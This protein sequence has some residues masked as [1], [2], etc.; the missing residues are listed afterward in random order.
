LNPDA[1]LKHPVSRAAHWGLKAGES[2]MTSAINDAF[3]QNG[4]LGGKIFNRVPWSD[5]TGFVTENTA[6]NLTNPTK[7]LNTL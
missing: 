7:S 3:N 6:Y 4:V 5:Y 1:T 2:V